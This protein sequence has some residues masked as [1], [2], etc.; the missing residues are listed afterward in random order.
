MAEM[1]MAVA[2]AVAFALVSLVAVLTL[3]VLVSLIAALVLANVSSPAAVSSCPASVLALP[4]AIPASV[5]PIIAAYDGRDEETTQRNG[6]AGEKDLRRISGQTTLIFGIMLHA[7]LLSG[8]HGMVKATSMGCFPRYYSF[9]GDE[10]SSFSIL[11]DQ[12]L[13]R[14]VLHCE[15]GVGILESPLP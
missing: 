7:V 6:E 1:E 14:R 2:M 12:T 3:T 9:V 15:L 13:L 5:V 4:L 10:V 8:V 11:G